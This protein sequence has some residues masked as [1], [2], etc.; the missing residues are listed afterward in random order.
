LDKIKYFSSLQSKCV[1]EDA[2]ENIDKSSWFAI[3]N[4]YF[5]RLISFIIGSV[6]SLV[7][8]YLFGLIKRRSKD[9]VPIPTDTGTQYGSLS[10]E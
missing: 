8:V 4:Q 2:D 10:L 7:S 3:D 5:D 1:E 6:T 9:Y